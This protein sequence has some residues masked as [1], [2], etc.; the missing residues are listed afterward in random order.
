MERNLN[1]KAISK[2]PST[3]LTEFNHPPDFGKL[4]N[5]LGNIANKVNGSA[6]ANEK[7]NIPNTGFNNFP[8][9]ASISK[10]PT[11]GPVQLNETNTRVKAIK[12]TPTK[13][14]M[15]DLESTLFTNPLGSVI[16]NMP[17]NAAPNI[18]KI[19]KNNTFGT[20]CVLSQFPKSGPRPNTPNNKPMSE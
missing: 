20:Q 9:T 14:P 5:Q 8:P 2:N 10:L 3:T 11:M 17:K 18:I 4:L 6:K 16:S 12:N 1:A 13:L 15:L 19:I 7:A